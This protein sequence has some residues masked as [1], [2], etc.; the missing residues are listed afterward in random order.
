MVSPSSD[1][2]ESSLARSNADK[3]DTVQANEA[4]QQVVPKKKMVQ[5]P[6]YFVSSI[7]QGARSRYS[8]V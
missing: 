2:P 1:K 8:G 5:R 6:V 4:D 7:L 3:V